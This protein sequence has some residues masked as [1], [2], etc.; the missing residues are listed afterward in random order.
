LAVAHI[1][2]SEILLRMT[3]GSI[4]YEFRNTE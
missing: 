1:T 3:G 4:M 2:G